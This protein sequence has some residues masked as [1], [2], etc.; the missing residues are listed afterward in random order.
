M[1]DGGVH[2]AHKTTTHHRDR[3]GPHT[4]NYQ[5]SSTTSPALHSAESLFIRPYVSLD[6]AASRHLLKNC[7]NLLSLLFCSSSLQVFFVSDFSCFNP[8]Y[9]FLFSCFFLF[10]AGFYLFHNLSV[11]DY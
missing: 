10:H 11:Y 7:K 1:P 2:C 3:A 5:T 9:F 6:H 8:G 4:A